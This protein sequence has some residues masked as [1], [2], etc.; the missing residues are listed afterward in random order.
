MW[1]AIVPFILV[2]RFIPVEYPV[3]FF[4][5]A[6]AFPFTIVNFSILVKVIAVPILC[7]DPPLRLSKL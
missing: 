4:E 1:S 6:Q 3:P 2:R 7:P 5:P